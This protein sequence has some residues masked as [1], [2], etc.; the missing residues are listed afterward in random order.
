LTVV[1]VDGNVVA[2]PVSGMTLGPLAAGVHTLTIDAT[3]LAGN[4]SPTSS[5]T[6]TIYLGPALTVTPATVSYSNVALNLPSSPTGF[7]IINNGNTGLPLAIT[8]ITLSGTNAADF[9][10]NNGTCGT[11]TLN[12]PV[13]GSCTFTVSLAPLSTGPKFANVNVTATGET[14]ASILLSGS[15]VAAVTNP[16]RSTSPSQTGYSTLTAAFAAATG[17]TTLQAINTVLPA[18][19]LTVNSTGTVNLTGG[20]DALWGIKSGMTVMQ[21]VMTIQNGSLVV[22]GLTIQ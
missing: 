12:I 9:Q 4:V 14:P 19:T 21:G 1:R 22:D 7:S 6:F 17:N 20:Y 3:D 2:N 5:V 11:G 13:G 15:G 18:A 10:L 8:G 16:V